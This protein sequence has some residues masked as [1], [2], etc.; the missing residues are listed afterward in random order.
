[1][2]IQRAVDLLEQAAEAG[3][4]NAMFRLSKLIQQTDVTRAQELLRNAASQGHADPQ[5]TVGYLVLQSV[6]HMYR[7]LNATGSSGDQRRR[8]LQQRQMKQER[9]RGMEFLKKAGEQLHADALLY[10]SVVMRKGMYNQPCDVQTADLLE[11]EAAKAGSAVAMFR[12]AER[13]EETQLV[14]SLQQGQQNQE[15]K[16]EQERRIASLTDQV[17]DLYRRAAEKHHPKAMFRYAKRFDAVGKTA[18]AV[19]MWRQAAELDDPDAMFALGVVYDTVGVPDDAETDTDTTATNITDKQQQQPADENNAT[20]VQNDVGGIGRNVDMAVAYYERALTRHCHPHAAFNL[21]I[22][23]VQ[24]EYNC[25]IESSARS[26]EALWAQ[27]GDGWERG[28]VVHDEDDDF[29]VGPDSTAEFLSALDIKDDDNNNS[30]SVRSEG[31]VANASMNA[32]NTKGGNSHPENL[33]TTADKG[34]RTEQDPDQNHKR[35][36]KTLAKLDETEDDGRALFN[37]AVEISKRQQQQQRQHYE[38]IRNNPTGSMPPQRVAVPSAATTRM[39]VTLYAAAAH[40]GHVT[41]L[42][43]VGVLLEQMG[44]VDNALK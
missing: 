30:L 4:P 7:H 28:I 41:A 3:L 37:L 27:A 26:M 35:L 9:D 21:G 31:I 24:G 5:Y 25:G 34:R 44:Q 19:R 42:F 12:V 1:M 11:R 39:L 22:L 36:K 17:T 13:L 14:I 8:Q 20:E 16:Q 15:Q 2:P 43:N 10:L 6:S 33:P 29:G 38:A 18:Q 23:A 40:K 32:I